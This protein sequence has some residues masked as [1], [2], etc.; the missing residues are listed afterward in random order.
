L[1]NRRAGIARFLPHW[2]PMLFIGGFLVVIGV[3]ATLIFFAGTFGG[4]DG[5]LWRD[6]TTNAS[7]RSG[8]ERP[9][10]KQRDRRDGNAAAGQMTDLRR[11]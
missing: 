7:R 4:W 1:S 2:V 11:R 8:A 9:A 10:A 5:R 6:L 3:N